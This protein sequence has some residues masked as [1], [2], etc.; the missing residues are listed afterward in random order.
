MRYCEVED[1]ETP[2]HPQWATSDD[3]EY[4]PAVSELLLRRV[5]L[6]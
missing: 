5:N 4:A 1:V 2:G 3:S 6:K